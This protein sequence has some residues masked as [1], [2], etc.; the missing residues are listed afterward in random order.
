MPG[1]KER[2]EVAEILKEERDRD[3]EELCVKQGKESFWNNTEG[4]LDN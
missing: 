1:S 3:N 2:I 4:T